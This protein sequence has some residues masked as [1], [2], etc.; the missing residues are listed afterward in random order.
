VNAPAQIATPLG[1][2]PYQALFCE[3]NSWQIARIARDH[4]L[5]CKVVFVTNERRQVAMLAQRASARPDGL[6]LWDYHV[7]AVVQRGL[8]WEA[9]DPDSALGLP[10]SVE[11]YVERSFADSDAWELRVQPRLRAIDA[12]AFLQGF[13]S[14]RRHMQSPR[15]GWL[16]PPPPWPPI[17]GAGGAYA[18][19]ALWNTD[20]LRAGPWIAPSELRETLYG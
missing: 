18:L 3:E 20:D 15:G 19:D 16:A 2:A 12:D 6:V 9:W 7:F 1:P 13:S 8:A 4:Q 14:S 10:C 17:L 11:R 5:P